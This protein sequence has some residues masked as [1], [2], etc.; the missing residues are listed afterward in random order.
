VKADH[1][2]LGAAHQRDKA[3]LADGHL[4]LDDTPP[5]VAA[6][7]ATSTAQSSQAK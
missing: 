6:A 5:L 3:M 1:V 7:R 2:S 4:F